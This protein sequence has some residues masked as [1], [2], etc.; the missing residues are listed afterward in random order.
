MKF[1]I[2]LNISLFFLKIAITPRD[3]HGESGAFFW[4]QRF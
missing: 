1:I 3:E 4:N 2:N